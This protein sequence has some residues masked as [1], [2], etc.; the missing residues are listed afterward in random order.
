MVVNILFFCVEN[1]VRSQ[2]A[3]A[4]ARKL[5]HGA[6]TVQSAGSRPARVH[7]LTIKI[8][9]EAGVDTTGLSSK[10]IDGID[11]AT[12][13]FAIR[14]SP[15]VEFP[16]LPPWVTR[17]D[18]L[19]P[20]P[21]AAEGDPARMEAAFRIAREAIRYHIEAYLSLDQPR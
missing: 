5:W 9:A 21:T 3:E 18:W 2:M 1:S 12:L 16:R 15:E 13:D 8:L 14:L 4:L 11:L 17:L 7:P 19:I 6:H 10:P 20:D